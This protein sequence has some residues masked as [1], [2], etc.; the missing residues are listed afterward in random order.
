ML[1]RSRTNYW[2]KEREMS[3]WRH[4]SSL[5]IT[6]TTQRGWKNLNEDTTKSLEQ[7]HKVFPRNDQLHIDNKTYSIQDNLHE[8]PSDLHPRQFSYKTDDKWIVLGGIHSQ[9]NF[10]SKYYEQ[11]I[12]RNL[13]NW[14]LFA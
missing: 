13:N 9:F 3:L 7:Y 14:K 6:V 4:Q 5:C 11:T 10:L 2:A 8:L 1:M 12:V